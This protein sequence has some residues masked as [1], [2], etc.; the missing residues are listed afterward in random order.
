M[1]L[2]DIKHYLAER[3]QATL[4]DI[5]L[6]CDADPDAVRGMLEQWIRKGKVERRMASDSCGSNCCSCDPATVEIYVWL[7]GTPGPAT[8]RLHFNLNCQKR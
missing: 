2:S 4:A 7:G 3:G 1:I 6:H 8:Q 5:A